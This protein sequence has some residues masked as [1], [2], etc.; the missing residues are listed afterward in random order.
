[1]K[2]CRPYQYLFALNT[3]QFQSLYFKKEIWVHDIY[4]VMMKR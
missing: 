2:V 4:T 3:V 1:M